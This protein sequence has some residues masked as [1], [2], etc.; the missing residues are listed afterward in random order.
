M[1]DSMPADVHT[2][3]IHSPVCRRDPLIYLLT[4]SFT[5]HVGLHV[6]KAAFASIGPFDE[7]LASSMIGTG[8]RVCSSGNSIPAARPALVGHGFRLAGGRHRAWYAEEQG[9]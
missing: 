4:D 7:K 1:W 8:T 9:C 3:L 6:P 2:K 5:Y